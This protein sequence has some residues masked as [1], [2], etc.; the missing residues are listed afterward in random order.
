MT[1]E[2]IIEHEGDYVHARQ[3][4]SDSYEASLKLWRGIVAACERHAC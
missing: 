1:H 4:G 3:Y 2:I